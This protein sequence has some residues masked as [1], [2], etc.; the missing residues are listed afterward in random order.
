MITNNI[1]VLEEFVDR[2][3]EQLV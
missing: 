1:L 2:K 3:Q